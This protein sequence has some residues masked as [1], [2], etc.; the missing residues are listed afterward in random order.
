MPV[1]LEAILS[2]WP[3]FASG[4]IMV[5]YLYSYFYW[6]ATFFTLQERSG[7]D[8]WGLNRAQPELIGLGMSL[9]LALALFFVNKNSG[10]GQAAK[11]GNDGNFKK[12]LS[13]RN[14]YLMMHDAELEPDSEQFGADELVAKEN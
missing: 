10:M 2:I 11:T 7:M 14:K 12:I 8:W 3:Y 9:V 5:K 6:K 1:I 4:F 13:K